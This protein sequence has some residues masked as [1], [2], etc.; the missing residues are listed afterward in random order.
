MQT[1]FLYFK[2]LQELRTNRNI[3]KTRILKKCNNLVIDFK[4]LYLNII[5]DYTYLDKNAIILFDQLYNFVGWRNG[6]YKALQETFDENEYKF[7][8]FTINAQQAVIQL[9]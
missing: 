3:K 4:K 9:N 8:A 7:R 1:V 5:F 6:E 2:A